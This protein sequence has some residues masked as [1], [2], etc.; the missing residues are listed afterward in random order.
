MVMQIQVTGQMEMVIEAETHTEAT[1]IVLMA[2]KEME[3]KAMEAEEMVTSHE[4]TETA[5]VKAMATHHAEDIR[6]K[7]QT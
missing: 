1:V 6:V 3:I 7:V 5:E 2:T 4:A